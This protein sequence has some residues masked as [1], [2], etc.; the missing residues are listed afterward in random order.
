MLDKYIPIPKECINCNHGVINLINQNNETN[1]IIGKSNYYKCNRNIRLRKGIIFEFYMHTPASVLYK[2]IE[3]WILDELNMNK[4]KEKLI[5]N[6]NQNLIY[7]FVD[8]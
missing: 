4:I 1:P 5:D 8:I 3:L 6:L 2:I 7:S